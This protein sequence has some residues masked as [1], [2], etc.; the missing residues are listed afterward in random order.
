MFARS[1]P[2][3]KKKTSNAPQNTHIPANYWHLL[4]LFA[5]HLLK[6]HSFE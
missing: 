2:P 4:S 1:T 5:L 6:F 3:P